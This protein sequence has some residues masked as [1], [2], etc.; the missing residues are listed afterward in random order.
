MGGG[1]IPLEATEYWLLSDIT[2]EGTDIIITDSRTTTETDNDVPAIYA[3][4]A[5]DERIVAY[6]NG[7]SVHSES[8]NF[9]NKDNYVRSYWK[10]TEPY[11]YW[12]QWPYTDHVL[13]IPSYTE[14]PGLGLVCTGTSEKLKVFHRFLD[15]YASYLDG[16][17]GVAVT[18]HNI[19]ISIISENGLDLK[20]VEKSM[21]FNADS[22]YEAEAKLAWKT[23][24]EPEAFI[25][26][27][28]TT[29]D[30]AGGTSFNEVTMNIDEHQLDS[31][32]VLNERHDVV[33]ET[34]LNRVL[35]YSNLAHGIIEYKEISKEYNN[36]MDYVDSVEDH[37]SQIL[38]NFY[39][40]NSSLPE[41]TGLIITETTLDDTTTSNNSI[42][43]TVSYE[44]AI[45]SVILDFIN[46]ETA[47]LYETDGYKGEDSKAIV[48]S[49]F[50]QLSPGYFGTSSSS[51]ERLFYVT[52]LR[53]YL[54]S[55][56]SFSGMVDLSNKDA[57]RYLYSELHEK[58]Y[59]MYLHDPVVL[60]AFF[61]EFDDQ[62][63][64]GSGT[65]TNTPER[66]LLLETLR[67]NE[68][69]RTIYPIAL[70]RN[71]ARVW[72]NPP[73]RIEKIKA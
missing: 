69:H 71:R 12:E 65:E 50:V 20:L 57:M 64:V 5:D 16:N 45:K 44:M 60:G 47:V 51:E 62:F 29:A 40:Y 39:R 42:S 38:R 2:A 21:A 8:V 3:Y 68:E 17:A 1:P 48:D 43:G 70:V 72:G 26:H 35:T 13:E 46:N 73:T 54:D 31:H 23:Q 4:S 55:Y 52:R 25:Y 56:S 22:L 67:L 15:N 66:D 30:C 18:T 37:T 6:I 7:Q 27:S 63:V 33:E 24:D 58:A 53:Q 14:C 11:G 10:R 61:G 32:R 49:S 9:S 28:T 36:T 59:Q 34:V 41:D 19:A